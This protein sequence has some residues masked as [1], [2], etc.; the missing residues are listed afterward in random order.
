MEK[1]ARFSVS[2]FSV[3]RFLGWRAQVFFSPLL[4][5]DVVVSSHFSSFASPFET[6]E[7]KGIAKGLPVP[8]S[9]NAPPP[10]LTSPTG[11]ACSPLG[12]RGAL[13][14]TR[15]REGGPESAKTLW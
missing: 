10:P 4:V 13:G 11:P 1:R 15:R 9:P 3:L 6:E 2:R 14:E 5:V 12:V 8:P 7:S